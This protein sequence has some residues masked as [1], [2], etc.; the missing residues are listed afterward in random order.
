MNY[1]QQYINYF[2]NPS[3]TDLSNFSSEMQEAL[4]EEQADFE[5]DGMTFDVEPV[6]I[7]ETREEKK[8]HICHHYTGSFIYGFIKDGIFHDIPGDLTSKSERKANEDGTYTFYEDK[9]TGK[10]IAMSE[11]LAGNSIGSVGKNKKGLWIVLFIIFV[12]IYWWIK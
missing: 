10:I 12:G 1:L 11:T 4:R 6:K 5:S 7:K 9:V 3:K 2:K 8:K